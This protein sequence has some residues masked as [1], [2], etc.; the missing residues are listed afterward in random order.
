[1]AL[2][3][4]CGFTVEVNPLREGSRSRSLENVLEIQ[5]F[6]FDFD[7]KSISES[8]E[9]IYSKLVQLPVEPTKAVMNAAPWRRR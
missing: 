1:M 5:R 8:R 6:V 7:F 3:P 9:E 2:N 4:Y